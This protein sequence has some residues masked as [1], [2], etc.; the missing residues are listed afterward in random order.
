[1]ETKVERNEFHK[2]R[3]NA[4]YRETEEYR[5]NF[6]KL[7]FYSWIETRD[8]WGSIDKTIG[9][10]ESFCHGNWWYLYAPNKSRRGIYNHVSKKS[11]TQS[12]KEHVEWVD[13]MS[14]LNDY[15][16]GSRRV[17]YNPEDGNGYFLFGLPEDVDYLKDWCYSPRL[18]TGHGYDRNNVC[19]V[20]KLK[21]NKQ[22]G[23]HVEPDT[24]EARNIARVKDFIL[25]LKVDGGKLHELDKY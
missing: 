11:A 19:Q 9:L 17:W 10:E 8:K 4:Q 21:Y 23:L 20:E 5:S 22:T 18:E 25:S 6:P 2:T 14:I 1:M 16:W 7:T 12:V 3:W 13:R 24:E 15:F